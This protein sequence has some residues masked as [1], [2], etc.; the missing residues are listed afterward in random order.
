MESLSRGHYQDQENC[1]LN[2]GVPLIDVILQTLY[3]R[4]AG[5]DQEKCPLNRGDNYKHYMSVLPVRTG[6]NVP[7]K[8][9]IITKITRE[10]YRPG[11]GEMSPNR[12]DITNII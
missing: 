3:E 6:R 8:E 1:P 7:L 4:F 5:Q 11:P 12:G 9:V 10:F 2:R